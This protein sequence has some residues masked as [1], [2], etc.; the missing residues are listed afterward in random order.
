MADLQSALRTISG[1]IDYGNG[2][3]QGVRFGRH[4]L[5][6]VVADMDYTGLDAIKNGVGFLEDVRRDMAKIDVPVTW[7]HGRY[8]AWMDLSRVVESMSCGR[9]DNRRIIEVPTGHQLRNGRAALATFQLVAEEAFAIAL[10]THQ[11]G[12]V[13]R[14]SAIAAA[15]A[16]ELIRAPKPELDA[17]TFWSDYLLGRR[18]ILGIELLASTASYR[19]FMEEQ[20]RM[21]RMNDSQRVADLGSGVG[22]FSLSLCLDHKARDIRVVEV[23]LVREA[24]LRA[25]TRRARVDHRNSIVVVQCAADFESLG[26]IIPIEDAKLDAVLASLLISYLASPERLLD[27]MRRIVRPGGRIV[28]SSM[29]RDADAMMI[30]RDGVMEHATAEARDKLGVGEDQVFD[31]LVR[32]FLNDGSRL[33]DLEERGRFQFFDEAELSSMVARAGFVDVRASLS[34]GDPPQ[35]AIVSARRP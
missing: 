22:E 12:A 2:L 21:L 33:V 32:D 19:N 35:A 29:V 20:I 26:A 1:G 31:D 16:A 11:R 15:R 8:D 6:G 7:I 4:E 13:P 5:V 3:V 28:V 25:R 27:E 30:F 23:D 9:T 24:L 34:F 10:G 14:V 17:K 18:R